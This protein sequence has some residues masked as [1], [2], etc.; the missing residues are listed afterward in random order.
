[1][2]EIN[3]IS[4]IVEKDNLRTVLIV[5]EDSYYQK[6]L[7]DYLIENTPNDI[8][9]SNV[10]IID[11]ERTND[12]PA[13]LENMNTYP[14]GYNKRFI[15]ILNVNEA[16][17]EL[18]D[19]LMEFNLNPNKFAK[20]FYFSK[21]TLK[22]F[23]VDKKYE[24][25]DK[26]MRNIFIKDI[27]TTNNIK[28]SKNL[29]E[30][31]TDKFPES[32]IGMEN[33]VEK[34]K[35]FISKGKIDE[36]KVNELYNDHQRTVFAE[37]YGLDK[38]INNKNF[39]ELLRNFNKTN[40][41]KNIFMEIGRIAWKYR[42]YLKIKILLDKNKTDNEIIS[43]TKISKFQFKY[44]KAESNKLKM[45][46]LLKTLRELQK[47]DKLL[48]SSDISQKTIIFNLIKNIGN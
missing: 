42:Q 12:I 8:Y 46:D 4:E 13:I 18:I 36:S 34:I 35:A 19:N 43:A 16:N 32:R 11:I 30:L 37:T 10:N 9:S 3:E 45:N 5:E 23:S 24:F 2:A 28:L 22:K 14:L 15:I 26:N 38:Y 17:K 20:I 25:N 6:K 44:I 41:E 1:M 31:V 27:L 40:F 47:A 39:K 7:L 21:K 48:K 33:E 29:M